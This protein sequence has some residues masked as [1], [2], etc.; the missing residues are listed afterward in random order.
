MRTVELGAQSFSD[1][2]L[3]LN[4]R[5]HTAAQIESA[6]TLLREK[7]FTAGL[8]IMTGLPGETEED[9]AP[10]RRIGLPPPP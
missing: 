6:F 8:Q 5:G 1:K 10:D 2:V 3:S 4:G 7:G 9:L